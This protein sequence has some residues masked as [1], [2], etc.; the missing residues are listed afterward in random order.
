[1]KFLFDTGIR[2]TYKNNK[3]LYIMRNLSHFV[4]S[5][6][7]FDYDK[8]YSYNFALFSHSQ[9]EVIYAQD[10]VNISFIPFEESQLPYDDV[11]SFFFNPAPQS[12]AFFLDGAS[13]NVLNNNGKIIQTWSFSS[14]KSEFGFKNKYVDDYGMITFFLFPSVLPQSNDISKMSVLIRSQLPDFRLEWD[15]LISASVQYDLSWFE[16]YVQ[17]IQKK[18]LFKL[19][20]QVHITIKKKDFSPHLYEI[21]QDLENNILSR[22]GFAAIKDDELLEAQQN[23]LSYDNPENAYLLSIFEKCSNGFLTS[24]FD[25]LIERFRK[26]WVISTE[27]SAPPAKILQDPLYKEFVEYYHNFQWTYSS[28]FGLKDQDKDYLQSLTNLSTLYE[29][30]GLASIKKHLPAAFCQLDDSACYLPPDNCKLYIGFQQQIPAGHL[31][32][33][34][35]LSADYNFGF[36]SPSFKKSQQRGYLTPDYII[37]NCAQ[38]FLLDAKFSCFKD[39]HSW[40]DLPNIEYIKDTLQKYRKI[41]VNNEISTTPIG[42]IYPWTYQESDLPHFEMLHQLILASY[43][44]YLL[45]LHPSNPSVFEKYFLRLVDR[46]ST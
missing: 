6:W 15:N 12:S 16:H 1:M 31:D 35:L 23:I 7:F 22:W 2:I 5:E 42:L 10:S 24:I 3:S 46:I 33:L 36:L 25:P 41:L 11:S 45:P 44:I 13:Y 28:Y 19:Y 26:Y 37:R 39:P 17:I 27:F 20:K 8:F 29:L 38:Y 32:W 4:T 40:M 30:Y 43:N 18:P 9:E 21:S 14:R 34:S